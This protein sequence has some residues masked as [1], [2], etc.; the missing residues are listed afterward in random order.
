M[1]KLTVTVMDQ[2][3]NKQ[4]EVTLPDD[5]PAS[6]II[7]KLVEGLKLPT[8]GPDG[9]PLSYRLHH[10]ASGKQLQENQTFTDAEVKNGDVLRLQPEITAGY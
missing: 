7:V 1:A 2:T 6:A 10:K 5:R 8:H 4:T 3:G 9:M